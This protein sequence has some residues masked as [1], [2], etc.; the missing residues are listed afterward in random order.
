[1]F[2]VAFAADPAYPSLP[3]VYTASINLTQH[4]LLGSSNIVGKALFDGAKGFAAYE[5]DQLNHT[6]RQVYDYNKK[7]NYLVRPFFGQD[8]CYS[9]ALPENSSDPSSFAPWLN[10]TGLNFSKRETVDGVD[11]QKFSLFYKSIK[12]TMEVDAWIHDADVPVKFYTELKAYIVPIIRTE[13]HY[14]DWIA[15]KA[16]ASK[17]N[18][19]SRCKRL[20]WQ[21]VR[22][23]VGWQTFES[24]NPWAAPLIDTHDRASELVNDESRIK[25]IQALAGPFWK[26][27]S[28]DRF[29]KVTL[30]EASLQLGTLKGARQMQ[31]AKVEVADAA[32]P[33]TFDAREKWASCIG[34][35][36]DQG[37]CGSCWAFAAVES[38]G[39]RIC[40]ASGGSKPVVL[41][42]EYLISCDHVD[43]GCGGGLTDNAW[44]FLQHSGVALDSCSPYTQKAQACPSKCNSTSQQL[45]LFSASSAFTP[46]LSLSAIQSEIVSRGPVETSFFVFEDFMNYKSGVYYTTGGSLQGGH[47]VKFMG[48]GTANVSLSSASTVAAPYWL[49]QNSWATSWGEKGFFRIRRGTNECGIEDEVAAGTFTPQLQQLMDVV[50]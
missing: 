32:P 17:F 4:S 16:D 5:M 40:I 25:R 27:G 24:L 46:G 49:V 36:R 3:N 28:N 22:E 8:R 34:P 9:F 12:A 39:D 45:K 7:L 13:V 38:F 47:A 43:Q 6:I 23:E 19:P 2:A 50:V 35:V 18:V 21:E 10:G 37:G 11:C 31:L 26:A 44:L 41:S 42:P 20:T 1:M 33:T 14:K 15:G 30:G 29:D 48:W